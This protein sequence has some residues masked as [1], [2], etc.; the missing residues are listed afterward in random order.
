MF[1]GKKVFLK[2]AVAI[3]K[4]IFKITVKLPCES[5]VKILEKYL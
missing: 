1:S 5:V 4:N 2:I 3:F